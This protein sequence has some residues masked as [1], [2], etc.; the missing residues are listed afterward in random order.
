MHLAGKTDTKFP[1]IW[2]LGI[3]YVSAK[4]VTDNYTEKTEKSVYTSFQTKRR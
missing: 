1:L 4:N 2:D 3:N